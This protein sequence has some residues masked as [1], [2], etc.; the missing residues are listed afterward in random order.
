MNVIGVTGYI[1]SGKTIVCRIFEKLGAFYIDADTV[2][3]KLYGP[4]CQ[5]SRKI[6]LFFGPDF[7]SKDGSVNRKKLGKVVFGDVRKLKILNNLIHPLVAAE[8]EKELR[9]VSSDVCV[10]E[11]FSF[12]KKYLGRFLDV[13]IF[14]DRKPKSDK[15]KILNL[16]SKPEHVDFLIDNNSSKA[17]LKTKV[18]KI[19]RK[20]MSR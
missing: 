20:I 11:A 16:Q 15:R 3:H 19:W 10:I 18:E 17:A 14:V 8:I 13:L 7:L 12:E 5:G 4:D 1:G 9:S 6:E 2:T